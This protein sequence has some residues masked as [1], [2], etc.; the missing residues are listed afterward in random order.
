MY[1][2]TLLQSENKI[3]LLAQA[4]VRIQGTSLSVDAK[5]QVGRRSCRI[6]RSADTPE[7]GARTYSL[8]DREH[9]VYRIEVRVVIAL[10]AWTKDKDY[11][12]AE[13]ILA[14]ARDD[15]FGCRDDVGAAGREYVDAFVPAVRAARLSIRIYDLLHTYPKHWHGDGLR[16]R[17]C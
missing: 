13:P 3:S 5:V 2:P 4:I 12:A 16:T 6:P 15:A 10:A 9:R 17:T 14:D 7:Y 1:A 8:A 11:R